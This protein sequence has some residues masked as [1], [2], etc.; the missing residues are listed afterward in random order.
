ME[1]VKAGR[2]DAAAFMALRRAAILDGCAEHYSREQLEAWTDPVTDDEIP[3]SSLQHFYVIRQDGD[4]IAGGIIIIETGTVAAMF[5]APGRRG[6]GLGKAI[7][8]HLVQIARDAGLK[9][10]NLASTLNAAP[11]YRSAGFRGDVISTYHSP[12]GV[13]LA[14]VPMTRDLA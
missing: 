6:I 14:C 11:F 8:A 12:R 1:I 4:L 7:M 10:L 2:E 5:V 9:S 3:D 13:D